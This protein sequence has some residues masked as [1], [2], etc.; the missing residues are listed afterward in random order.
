MAALELWAEYTR[1]EVHSIFSPRTTFTPQAGTWG[2]QGIVRIPDRQNDW[3]F[4]VTFGQEQGEHAFNESITVD[5]V[6]SWQSQP[7]QKFSDK[8]I[9]ELIQHDDRI[10]SIHLFLRSTK[11]TPYSYLGRLGYLTH[12][13][14][15]EAPVYFQ[16]QLLDWPIPSE[17]ISKVGLALVVEGREPTNEKSTAPSNSLE[18]VAAP[19]AKPSRLGVPTQ[20][21]KTQKTP[22][23]AERDHKNRQLGLRGELLVLAQE[24]ATLKNAGRDDL[25]QKVVHVSIS[26]GDGAGYDVQSFFPDGR[27]HYIE[28][29]TTQGKAGTPFFISPNEIAFSENHMGTYSLIRVFEF[30]PDA[31]SGK[32][33][34]LTGSLKS[35][36]ELTPTEYRAAL[37]SA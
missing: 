30:D 15:R 20:A 34:V 19:K 9:K 8:I 29:K 11:K 25:A 13:L 32:A 16:W 35:V 6:L 18:F 17:I 23:Y 1:E 31:N 10:N 36:L 4:F 27:Q 37:L 28:V 21:F 2:L 22:N 14:D 33:F 5:G 3:V 26:V 12:D 7:A 24:I